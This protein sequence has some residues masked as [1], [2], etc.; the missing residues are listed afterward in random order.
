LAEKYG[1][2][3]LYPSDAASRAAINQYLFFHVSGTGTRLCSALLFR[4]L[5][6]GALTGKLEPI[7]DS[8]YKQLN[9]VFNIL[10]NWLGKTK[11]IA[12]N[13]L[14]I[15]DFA[16]YSELDQLVY[17]DLFNF[18]DYP[19][20]ERW[21]GEMRLLPY[22]DEVRKPLERISGFLKKKRQAASKL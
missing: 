15:A 6:M 14:T 16:A 13:S 21:M 18:K 5:L 17:G 4:P 20:I 22:H 7:P 8:A 9:G 11:F 1:W 12:S 3:D 2:T 10:N 19:N